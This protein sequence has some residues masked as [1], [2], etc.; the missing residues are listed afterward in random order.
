MK[1]II[2]VSAHQGKINWEKVKPH[3]DGAIIRVGFGNNNIDEW[4]KYNISECNRLGIPVGAYWFSYTFTDDGKALREAQYCYEALKP[5]KLQ[6]PVYFDWEYDSMNYAKK[7]GY[8][9][10]KAQITN[11]NKIFIDFFTEKGISAGYYLNY[12]YSKN[13]IDRKSFQVLNGMHFI[14]AKIT[15]LMEHLTFG[16][17]EQKDM[18]ALMEGLTLTS[19]IMN[20]L[21]RM[22]Q[23]LN[24]NRNQHQHLFHSLHR[25]SKQVI[26]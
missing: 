1:I 25:Q 18:K 6:L 24:Q 10:T 23:H 22:C 17:M 26:L 9:P 7:C 12:D 14:E 13:Y 20:Q 21:L 4:F 15:N 16:S 3:I 8:T 5:Y 11:W 2:D 19:Y